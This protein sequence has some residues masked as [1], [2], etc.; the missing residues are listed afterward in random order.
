[1]NLCDQLIEVASTLEKSGFEKEAL[2]VDGVLKGYL[3]N[4]TA[5]F[6]GIQGYWIKNTRCWQNCYRQN[7]AD[8]PNKPTQEIWQDCHKE[9]V[10]SLKDENSTWQKYASSDS[11]SNF[12]SNTSKKIITA[13]KKDFYKTLQTEISQGQPIGVAWI[14]AAQKNLDAYSSK[15][16]ELAK[17][18]IKVAGSWTKNAMQISSKSF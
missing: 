4:K 18:L 11:D 13:A 17:G 1:M 15:M 6:V 10:Q 7:R 16:I 5:Q 12:E 9:Y 3:I 8:S 2:S 14:A